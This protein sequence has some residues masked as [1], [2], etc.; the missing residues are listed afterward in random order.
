[1]FNEVECLWGEMMIG[2]KQLLISAMYRPPSAPASY[3]NSILDVLEKADSDGIDMLVL[4]D[5]NYDYK[6]DE[7]LH[8]NPLHYIE[9]LHGMSQLITDITRKTHVS[10]TTPDVILTTC[11]GLHTR[12][13]VETVTLSDHYMI[14]TEIQLTQSRHSSPH[15]DV[16]F[17]D[18]KN[19]NEETFISDL[20]S[21]NVFS[22]YENEDITWTQWK[23]TSNVLC[24]KHA[25]MKT[26]RLKK[27]SNP[28][29]TRDIIEMMY[30][31]DHLHYRATKYNDPEVMSQYRTLRNN[32][33]TTIRDMKLQYFTELHENGRKN[34]KLFWSEMKKLVPKINCKS[35]PKS[36]TADEFNSYFISVPADIHKTFK[37]DEDTFLWK[38]NK[39][40]HTFNFHD[41]NPDDLL[42]SLRSLKK[43]SGNDI[44][45]MDRKLI[46]TAAPYIVNSLC[47]IINMSL[48][49]G[50]VHD[51]WKIARVTPIYKNEGDLNDEKN[52]RPISVISHIAK[53]VEQLICKQLVVYLEENHFISPDQS[54]YLKRRSTQTSLH[55]VIDDWLENTNEGEITGVCLLDISK[56]F[57]TID[58]RLLIKKFDMYGIRGNEINWFSSYL[59]NRKQAV[60]CNGKLSNFQVIDSGVPQGSVLGPFLFLLFINDITNFTTEDSVV[61]L[62]A[63]DSSLYASGKSV[64]EVRTKLQTCLDNISMWY[65][66]NR[67]KINA[68]KSKVMLIG[69]RC[70][71]RSLNIDDFTIYYDNS[72]LELVSN[73][74]YLGL[75]ISSDLTWDVHIIRLCKMLYYHLSILRRLRKTVPQGLLLKIYKTYIQPKLEYGITLWGCT[76]EGNLDKVQR[77]QNFAARLITGNFDYI[78][79]R[80]LELVKSLRLYTVRERRDFF[81]ATLMFKSIHGL[82]PTYLSDSIV[83]N[84]DVNGYNT[85][86]TDTMDVYIPKPNKEIYRNS[87]L[88]KGGIIWNSLP[89]EVKESS[90]IDEFK[91]NYAMMMSLQ[92]NWFNGSLESEI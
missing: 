45:G 86:S 24:D 71:L 11:P 15:N 35:I 85:R 55:R 27:R 62:F 48:S 10:Q 36:M 49:N 78:N 82:A 68:N 53:I 69:T 26:A 4:G 63:D 28:W 59:T 2:R 21:N 38:G 23:D 66:S 19:F 61:N 5:L 58:H 75:Y 17:R 81:L 47:Q 30:T 33:T 52:Y 88:Y 72:P 67:L 29:I 79:Y 84:F 87:L 46:V 22:D 39:S 60:M 56:C 6:L 40:I 80:G 91:Y 41:I 37:N 76:T 8:K 51:D 90:N 1:M 54:A 14:F 31:R 92:N 34:P 42:N 44:L 25:P 32:I 73:A 65:K 3:F 12:S 70:Q 74:K 16:T 83:M 20:Q 57:D 89:D 77:V 50:I 43:S 18:F 64:S 7:N 13:G 9:N